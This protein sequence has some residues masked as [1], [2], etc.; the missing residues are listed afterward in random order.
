M[1]DIGSGSAPGAPYGG[2]GAPALS[3]RALGVPAAAVAMVGWAASGVIA[4]GISE[5]GPLA[6]VFWRMW[7]YTGLVALFLW[8]N[9]TPLRLS[10]IKVSFWGGFSLAFDIML[11]FVAL[12]MTTVANATVVAS[13]QPLL[14]LFLAPR[15]FG[16][17]PGRRHWGLAL[18]AIGGIAIVVLGSSGLTE[19]SVFGDLLA[20]GA[21][22]AW[23]GL[24]RVLEA[25][26][27][28]DRCGPV[29]G[30]QCAGVLVGGHA[31]RIGLGA[32][33]RLAIGGG[34]AVARHHGH[35]PR[36]CQSHADDLSAWVQTT[37]GV[38]SFALSD[39]VSAGFNYANFG[40]PHQA[41]RLLGSISE[42]DRFIL[43]LTRP[44]ARRARPARRELPRTPSLLRATLSPAVPSIPANPEEGAQGEPEPVE[45]CR[46]HRAC[47]GRSGAACG[48]AGVGDDD[49][50]CDREL[51]FAGDGGSCAPRAWAHWTKYRSAAFPPTT[52]V[53][54]CPLA[55]MNGVVGSGPA[56]GLTDRGGAGV[57]W[58]PTELGERPAW[59]E[60]VLA[61]GRRPPAVP[62]GRGRSRRHP[63]GGRQPPLLALGRALPHVAA[64]PTDPR[65]ACGPPTPTNASQPH[66]ATPPWAPSPSPG[67]DLDSGFDPATLD[68]TS[69]RAPRH[70]PDHPRR[71]QPPVAYACG[72][73]ISPHRRGPP[74]RRGTRSRSPTRAPVVT[75]TV[76]AGRPDHQRVLGVAVGHE[77]PPAAVKSLTLGE[78]GEID[79]DPPCPPLRRTTGTGAVG[80]G[81]RRPGGKLGTRRLRGDRRRHPRRSGWAPTDSSTL[82]PGR[83]DTGGSARRDTR[84]NEQQ[85]LY[86]IR[87]QTAQDSQ[88][89]TD[90]LL[91]RSRAGARS[92]PSG[93]RHE[94][95]SA[96][97]RR[98]R[99][100]TPTRSAQRHRRHPSPPAFDAEKHDY[101]ASVAHGTESVTVTYTPA[102]GVTGHRR[103]TRRRFLQPAGHQVALNPSTA[104]SSSQTAILIVVSNEAG[105]IDSY[106]ITVTRAA[107]S[108]GDATLSAPRD[109]RPR[110]RPRLPL[111]HLHLYRDRRSR[112][113][114]ARYGDIR[115]RRVELDR[116]GHA[117]RFRL[118]RRR[119][120]GG[121]PAGRDHRHR[122]GDGPGHPPPPA[123]PSPLTGPRSSRATP[124]SPA[125]R[126]PGW[127]SLRSSAPAPTPR[128]RWNCPRA[129]TSTTS[130]RRRRSRRRPSRPWDSDCHSLH[131]GDDNTRAHYYR[132]YVREPTLVRLEMDGFPLNSRMVL[133]S[134]T[135]P[136]CMSSRGTGRSSTASRDRAIPAGVLSLRILDR[137]VYI[138]EVAEEPGAPVSG[139]HGCSTTGERASCCPTS[140]PRAIPTSPASCRL[141]TSMWPPRHTTPRGSR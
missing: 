80:A 50:G 3:E 14:M 130:T 137:G 17:Q 140:T 77:A 91:P 98:Q 81:A 87:L 57:M 138:V 64:R 21:L 75:V 20:F 83:P 128:S 46:G 126:S 122:R 33:L 103:R 40:V 53:T 23:T 124:A 73:S 39:V 107:T 11:F 29:H 101:S 72:T 127:T 96:L 56:E 13:L 12:R 71:R 5:L 136:S 36:R 31:V 55:Q 76:T 18:V 129:A 84:V 61:R 118:D 28:E 112:Y 10:S 15:I 85:T 105:N 6:V 8:A 104:T 108:T 44:R 102:S 37:A 113:D 22:F 141:R 45:D 79:F 86:T 4:K 24:F 106:V 34:V 66:T 121:A 99:R 32:G 65:C 88:P 47:R 67:A 119:A 95:H 93:P 35:R 51:R 82:T 52:G 59:D 120:P 38:A 27:A 94:V 100:R 54:C 109:R 25:E 97:R 49:V 90:N 133:R 114:E 2:R 43:A 135:A 58:P 117:R 30:R 123:T 19:W 131:I 9:R 68:Y 116:G 70:R 63:R 26:H 1:A 42:G 110:A 48:P 41:R 69:R 60:R 78:S 111:D 89:P 134:A 16:E 7:L 74:H 62:R 115:D 125:W 139:T 132:M 92:W